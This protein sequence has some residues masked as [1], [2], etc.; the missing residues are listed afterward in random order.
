MKE[1]EI[2]NGDPK[3]L[4]KIPKEKMEHI[5][6]P[7]GIKEIDENDFK[8]CISLKAIHIMEKE[9]VLKGNECEDFENIINIECYPETFEIMKKRLMVWLLVLLLV[10]LIL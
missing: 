8:N 7:K 9:I 6:I 3:W 5:Y 2:Y 4:S 1:I 10:H